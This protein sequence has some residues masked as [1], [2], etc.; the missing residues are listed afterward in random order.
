VPQPRCRLWKPRVT[1]TVPPPKT[2]WVQRLLVAPVLLRLRPRWAPSRRGRCCRKS[3]RTQLHECPQVALVP[4]TTPVRHLRPGR[5]KPVVAPP[6]VRK[7]RAG[8]LTVTKIAS[9]V[10]GLKRLCRCSWRRGVQREPSTRSAAARIPRA[11]HRRACPRPGE[12]G[13]RTAAERAP[14][15]ALQSQA[16]RGWGLWAS[17]QARL[18]RFPPRVKVALPPGALRPRLLL[19]CCCLPRVWEWRSAAAALRPLVPGERG[20]RHGRDRALPRE[21]RPPPMLPK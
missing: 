16:Q 1:G 2:A 15:R 20:Y 7:R 14:G 11:V 18:V 8:E 17:A 19:S 9:R 3:G 13:R 12:A 21:R 5:R 4:V 6:I 10:L